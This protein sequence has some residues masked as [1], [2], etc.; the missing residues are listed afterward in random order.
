MRK[1]PVENFAQQV[2]APPA[3]PRAARSQNANPLSFARSVCESALR[4]KALSQNAR[5]NIPGFCNGHRDFVFVR[6]LQHDGNQSLTMRD[7]KNAKPKPSQSRALQHF[8]RGRTQAP[9]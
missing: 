2:G 5:R 1:I 8:A 9:V 4:N 7:S 6:K 3:Q